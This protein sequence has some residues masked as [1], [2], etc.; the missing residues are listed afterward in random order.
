MQ[1]AARSRDGIGTVASSSHPGLRCSTSD[2][3]LAAAI[4]EAGARANAEVMEVWVTYADAVLV[5]VL[6]L[7]WRIG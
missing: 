1:R 7:A 3:A 2:D 6:G 4:N 5:D